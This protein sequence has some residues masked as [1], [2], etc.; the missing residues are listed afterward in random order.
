MSRR[1]RFRFGSFHFLSVDHFFK[2]LFSDLIQISQGE[3]QSRDYNNL[4]RQ[5]SDSISYGCRQHHLHLRTGSFLLEFGLHRRRRK[6]RRDVS[7]QLDRLTCRLHH[8]MITHACIAC[9]SQAADMISCPPINTYIRRTLRKKL[10]AFIFPLYVIFSIEQFFY[11]Y[12]Y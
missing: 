2:L 6:F 8:L 9:L 4:P 3:T 7:R 1:L 12:S 11:I 10:S 5:V